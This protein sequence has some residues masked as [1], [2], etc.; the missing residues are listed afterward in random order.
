MCLWPDEHQEART[1]ISLNSGILSFSALMWP[2][3]SSQIKPLSVACRP[4]STYR[5]HSMQLGENL[6]SRGFEG[7]FL[8][9]DEDHRHIPG[10]RKD[11]ITDPR[12][13][14]LLLLLA[15]RSR[16]VSLGI[17]A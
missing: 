6:Q 5:V 8:I 7:Q 1:V 4:R 2:A 10:R 15:T 13:A 17:L 3:G 9:E 11:S 16:F 12:S 14:R